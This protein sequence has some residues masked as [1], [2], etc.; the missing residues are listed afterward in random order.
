VA[1]GGHPAD[2]AAVAGDRR[3]RVVGTGEDQ[4]RRHG[5][6][7]CEGGGEAGGIQPGFPAL[8]G[9]GFPGVDEVDDRIVEQEQAGLAG[10]LQIVLRVVVAFEVGKRGGEV[11]AE[12]AAPLTCA[13][14]NGPIDDYTG[15]DSEGESRCGECGAGP[16]FPEW[17]EWQVLFNACTRLDIEPVTPN[18]FRRTFCSW[19]AQSGVPLLV[20][21]K[22]MGHRSSRMVEHVYARFGADDLQA[23]ISRLPD[24]SQKRSNMPS[25]ERE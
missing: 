2:K 25:V 10:D 9:T 17:E 7:R 4:G 18:D 5:G 11:A 6:E 1:G 23:A 12:T 13:A 20:A 19:L 21:V 16:L 3:D 8:G 14:C 22:L 15:D 24:L